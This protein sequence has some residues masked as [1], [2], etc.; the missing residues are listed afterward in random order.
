MNGE[1]IKKPFLIKNTKESFDHLVETI[2]ELIQKYG[3]VHTSASIELKG[4]K[5]AINQR[6][7]CANDGVIHFI[8]KDIF[9]QVLIASL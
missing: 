7:S 9:I 6:K 8:P 3:T 2:E 5:K 4:F 1:Y